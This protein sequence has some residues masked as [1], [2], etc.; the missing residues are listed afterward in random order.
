MKYVHIKKC[1][2]CGKVKKLTFEHIPPKKA[3]NKN[4]SRVITG[5][6]FINLVSSEERM[7]WDTS[8][9]HYV[10][11]QRGAGLFSLCADCNNLTGVLYGDEYCKVAN[12]FAFYMQEN[13]NEINKSI[14]LSLNVKDMYP[15]RFIK[16]VLSMFCSTTPGLIERFPI[17]KELLL[18]KDMN[19]NDLEFKISV[20]LMK[21]K[22]FLYT[23]QNILFL[24]SGANRVI[25]SMDLYPFGFIFDYDKNY[26][27]ESL[28][29]ITSFLSFKYDDCKT[30]SMVLPIFERNN[31]FPCDF[32]TKSETIDI[33]NKN[34][35]NKK[36]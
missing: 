4:G 11:Q 27:D 30:M 19:A 14:G 23:G 36:K 7:P 22:R 31:P 18:N 8:G 24:K 21:N 20:F 15:L 28:C 33:I 13:E 9:L 26:K 3:L 35:I 1:A 10:N 25:S 12:A 6:E 32:R 2:I 5:D 16:Q 29:D 34:K 17:I